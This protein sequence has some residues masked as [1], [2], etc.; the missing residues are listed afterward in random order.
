MIFD[1]D[2]QWAIAQRLISYP[3]TYQVLVQEQVDLSA[4]P[5]LLRI[6]QTCCRWPQ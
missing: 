2:F 4:A 1:S 6:C 3:S 5:R